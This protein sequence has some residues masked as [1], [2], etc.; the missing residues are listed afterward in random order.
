MA[1][2]L[3]VSENRRLTSENGE[4]L[5]G[6]ALPDHLHDVTDIVGLSE[7]DAS[8]HIADATDAHDASAISVLDA[9]ANFTGTDVEAVLAEL[10]AASGAGVA[11]GDKGDITVSAGGATWTIDANA[12]TLAKLADIATARL[13]GRATAGAGDPEELTAA[14]VRSLLNVED[15]ATADQTAAEILAKLLTVD[16]T[17]S[18][19]DADKLDGNEATAFAIAGHNHDGTYATAAHN[20]D[21]AYA[22]IDGEYAV[23]TVAASGA[24]ETLTLAPAHK[25]TMDQ[26]CT[27]TFPTPTAGHTFL[28]WLSGA[29]TPTFPASVDWDTATAPTYASPSLYGFTTMDGGTTWIGTLVASAAA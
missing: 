21:T 23:N 3:H 19:L 24:T 9:A 15:G 11:D 13:L 1:D 4:D 8:A 5:A 17:G 27:F 14:Q 20:H 12:V 2:Q 26:N 10:A 29:F 18:G 6:E 25:V 22:D 16:G 7:S 28:L